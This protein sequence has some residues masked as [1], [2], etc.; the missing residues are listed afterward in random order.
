M[1]LRVFSSLAVLTTMLALGGLLHAESAV[2]Q[3]TNS[4]YDDS[5]PY[6]GGDYVVW[7]G[8]VDGDWEIFLRNVNT[9]GASIQ[10]T[11]NDYDDISPQTDGDYVVWLGFSH[12]GGQV[13]LYDIGNGTITQITNDDYVDSPPKIADGRVVWASQVVTDFVEPGEII[14]YDVAR[15]VTTQLTDD[16]LDD[17]NPRINSE[18]VFWVQTDEEEN[19]RLFLYDLFTGGTS[20]AP[21]GFAWGDSPQIDENLTVLTRHDGDSRELFVLDTSSRTYHQIT[22]DGLQ[23]RYPSISGCYIAWM[24]EGEIFLARQVILTTEPTNVQ[25]RSFLASWNRPG[26]SVDSY[27]L[28]V[29]SG[30]DSRQYVKGFKGKVVPGA[31]TSAK[32]TGLSPQ[33]TYYY[34][35]RP[36]IDRTVSGDSNVPSV[37]T[38]VRRNISPGLVLLLVLDADE[39][40]PVSDRR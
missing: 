38:L 11:D 21:E 25:Q 17:S 27:L 32:I 26:V 13:F 29:W 39:Q 12:S 22:D 20:E 8:K 10:I 35:V 31:S 7:Q 3:I 34:R 5:L 9:L 16:V 23:G 18:T 6:V 24:A 37:A 28:D 40:T 2:I 36:V 1:K 4:A 15:D 30:K 33:T 19:A 14:L